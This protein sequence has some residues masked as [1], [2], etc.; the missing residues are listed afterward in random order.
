[1]AA[2]NE[3]LLRWK[4]GGGDEWVKARFAEAETVVGRWVGDKGKLE[5]LVK[6]AD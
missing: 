2:N 1:M 4:D 6:W 5:M 3:C